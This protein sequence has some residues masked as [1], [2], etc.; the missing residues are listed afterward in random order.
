MILLIT[1]GVC[2]GFTMRV[3]VSVAAVRM[4]ESFGWSKTQE[5][6][7]FSAFY[8]GYMLGQLPSAFMAHW[9]GAKRMLAYSVGL[10]SILSIVFPA[11]IKFSYALGIGVRILI[12]LTSSALFPSCY[13]LYKFWIP[14]DE[15]TS[16]ISTV[17][18]GMYLVRN[19]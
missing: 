2:V 4:A 9:F 8:V 14:R 12:G 3:N 6:L 15:K 1:S 10:T 16:M 19:S 7:L 13:Y 18:S 11:S 17:L 5:G